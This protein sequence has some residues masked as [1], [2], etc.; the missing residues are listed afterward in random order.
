MKLRIEIILL[1]LFWTWP[2]HAEKSKAIQ[3]FVLDEHQVYSIP[4]STERVTT[5]S[6][7]GPIS[8]VEAAQVTVDGKTPGLFQIA[9]TRGSYFL[10][11]RALGKKATTNVNIR[12]NGHTYVLQLIESDTPLYS[13]IFQ[14]A[15][16]PPSNS[17]SAPVTPHR[18]LALLDE[19][20]A[21]PLL[22]EYHPDA[23]T[24]V[25]YTN[26]EHVSQIMDYKT[27]AIQLEEAFRFSTD[28][29]LIFRVMLTNKTDQPLQYR[30][31][32]FALKVGE[33]LYPQ[34]ISDAAGVI[35]PKFQVPAYFAIT[36]TPDGGRNNISLKND[37]T[38]I[39]DAAPL[40][41][42]KNS[43]P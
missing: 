12:W 10:S 34:S 25:E 7:P 22:R 26:Y 30:P 27:Y 20:K 16:D 31:D 2:A 14:H 15:V 6:F 40:E 43:Q 13:V 3:D 11:V 37:F 5:I 24:A 1:A 36:G 39:L 18:L 8:A 17:Q 9:H 33:R 29:T 28:D 19:A 4:V 35:P 41:P 21:F 38:V 42:R 23:V 32:G